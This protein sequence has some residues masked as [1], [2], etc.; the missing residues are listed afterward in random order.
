MSSENAV[1]INGPPR[2]VPLTTSCRV[3]RNLR[4]VTRD[5]VVH[6]TLLGIIPEYLDDD[7]GG[8][9]NA[10]SKAQKAGT[11]LGTPR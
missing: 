4:Y 3:G 11:R 8:M 2:D 7:V 5:S 1:L 10:G 9:S 6:G